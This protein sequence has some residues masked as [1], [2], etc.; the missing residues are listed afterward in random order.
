[1]KEKKKTRV[2]KT[3]ESSASLTGRKII[4]FFSGNIYKIISFV[5][6]TN[7]TVQ[8]K[9]VHIPKPECLHNN[10]KAGNPTGHLNFEKNV[11]GRYTISGYG[12]ILDTDPSELPEVNDRRL[13]ATAFD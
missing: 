13:K 2:P 5:G 10:I 11:N 12:F 3:E 6:I 1:M 7:G 8:V 9:P 4:R